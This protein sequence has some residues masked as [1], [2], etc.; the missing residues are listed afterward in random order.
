[1]KRA[2]I[3]SVIL[4]VAGFWIPAAAQEMEKTVILFRSMDD[5]DIPPDPAICDPANAGFVPNVFLGASLWSSTTRANNGVVVKEKVRQIGTATA[6]A[7]LTDPTF[8]PFDVEA[9]FYFE[10]TVG[11]LYLAAEGECQVTNNALLEGG[12]VFVGCYLDV[13]PQRSTPGIKWGQATSNS[14]FAPIAV[15]GF[16][17]GS[18]WSIQLIWE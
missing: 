16:E 7:L 6:C 4:A 8:T 1:M 3:F 2:L 18:F 10:G 15:P 17:T 9:P 5:P 11:D 14:T 13:I 12:P